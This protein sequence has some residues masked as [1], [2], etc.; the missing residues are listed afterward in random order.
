LGTDHMPTPRAAP[1]GLAGLALALPVMAWIVYAPWR[2]LIAKHLVAEHVCIYGG[3]GV[4]YLRG[5]AN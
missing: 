1:P 3:S 4:L 5:L 2:S